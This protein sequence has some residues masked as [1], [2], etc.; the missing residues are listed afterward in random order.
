MS[1]GNIFQLHQENNLATVVLNDPGQPMNTW[2]EEA[3]QEFFS[4]LDELEM[5]K[6]LQGVVFISGKPGNFHS[7]ANLKYINSLNSHEELSRI[8][9]KTHEAFNRLEKASFTSL[10]AIN[11]HC[12]G[13]GYEFALACTA[14]IAKDSKNTVI[15]LPETQLGLLPGGGGTQR[16]SRLIGPAAIELILS[17][18]TLP[19]KQAQEK[20]LIDRVTGA[21]SDLAEEAKEYLKT[22]ITGKEKLNRPSHDFSNINSIAA[23]VRKQ[24]LKASRGRELPGPMMAIKSI[25]DGVNL[26]LEEGLEKEKEY[27]LDVALSREA[28]G[29]IHTF[30][31]KTETDR[32]AS[33]VSAGFQ[34]KPI[35][36][37]AVIGFGNMG[38]GITIDLLRRMKIPVM[39]KDNPDMLKKGSEFVRKILLDM[40]EKN[41]LKDPVEQLTDLLI[42]VSE[43]NDQID[44]VDLVI[45]A[46][47][48]ETKTKQEAFKDI[49]SRVSEDCL[50]VSNTS[51]IPIDKMAP[52]VSNPERFAGL[53]FF[54]PVWR[55]ELVEIVKGAN[56][57]QE[58]LNNLLAFSGNMRKRP[59]VCKDNPGFVVNALLLPYFLKMYDLMEQGV[60]IE[61]IDQ[62]MVKFGLPL[63]PVR[64]IDEMGIDVHYYAFIA[65][66]MEP[67][68]IVKRVFND[69]RYGFKKSGKGYFLGDGS[70]DPEVLDLI[71][72]DQN[73]PGLSLEEIQ[74]NLYKAFVI[75]GKE[76][77][78]QGIVDSPKA[79]D[80]GMIWGIGFPPE[81]GGPMK[82]ADL[83]GLSEQI[84]GKPFYR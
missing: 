65:L 81:K 5:I 37:I 3:L 54:S 26:T 2:T 21:D 69:G 46:V 64:L 51:T 17:G 9:D 42:P 78:D 76:L 22:I 60:P 20:G 77:L 39:V 25:E 11:G 44:D 74:H 80:V 30:F 84:Q 59:I 66:G 24:A 36:K 68:A 75:R 12:L 35:R 55:M 41:K 61:S 40:A 53:H 1:H 27:F 57:G 58:T 23:E 14:R 71:A 29:S 63:G 83:T 73:D 6:G 16:L 28:K 7:G 62:A 70:V 72:P 56:T 82:W 4:L 67:P 38:R 48:E 34:A 52:F 47:F 31:L 43:Y 33:L 8:L 10:A 49:T 13:G 15:G 50:L 19:A 32:P 18:K 79:I 45:E